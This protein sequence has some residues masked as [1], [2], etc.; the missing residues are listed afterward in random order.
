MNLLGIGEAAALL[1][2]STKTV[3]RMA[4]AGKIPVIR[5]S[6]GTHRY[7]RSDVESLVAACRR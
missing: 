4:A 3:R 5:L 2:V 1:R 7:A 6:A